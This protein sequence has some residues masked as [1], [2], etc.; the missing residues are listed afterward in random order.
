MFDVWIRG[1]GIIFRL[2]IY[3][4]KFRRL[5]ADN[6]CTSI[7]G[8]EW[9]RRNLARFLC[10]FIFNLFIKARLISAYLLLNVTCLY[11]LP[12]LY[13]ALSIKA[14]MSSIT[15]I[16]MFVCI[17]CIISRRKA[18]CIGWRLFRCSF[19]TKQNQSKYQI[20]YKICNDDVS[21]RH[22]F[23]YV[24]WDLNERSIR[25]HSNSVHAV[26]EWMGCQATAHTCWIL[27]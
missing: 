19:Y 17:G 11:Y 20:R 15:A 8:T 13:L 16:A 25:G 3:L 10:R 21:L 2:I 1:G 12:C 22:W 14:I 6:S 27:F 5:V 4:R 23:Q 7:S 9:A 26:F 24:A 18:H